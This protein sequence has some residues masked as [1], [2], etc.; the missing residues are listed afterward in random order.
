M[1][2]RSASW[3]FAAQ[4]LG[5]AVA[6]PVGIVLARAL[7]ASG[8]GTLS[9]VQLITQFSVVVLGLG[10][11]SAFLYLA[12]RREVRGRDAAVLAMGLG[13]AAVSVL[14]AAYAI[15]GHG[16]IE[17]LLKIPSG[18]LLLV[19]ILLVGPALVLNLMY[20]VVLGS[21]AVRAATS[22]INVSMALQLAAYAGLFAFGALTLKAAVAVWAASVLGEAVVVSALGLRVRAQEGSPMGARL[23]FERA[24]RYGLTM[25]VATLVGQA[26]LRVDMLL[27]SAHRGTAEVGVYSV[28]VTFAELLWLVPS[29]LNAVMLPKVS[30]EGPVALDVTLRLQRVLWPLTLVAGTV[31]TLIAWPVVPLLY[32]REFS[33]SIIPLALLM[34]GAVAM[35][36]TVLP[37]AY[38]SGSG[39]PGE[40]T[41]ASVA[42]LGV[43]VVA[44]V[45]LI[46]LLGAPGAAIASAVSYSV[47]AAVV[48]RAFARFAEVSY[49]DV[50]L[51]A[52]SDVRAL[53]DGVRQVL[54]GDAGSVQE[55]AP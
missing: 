48:I 42:N 45:V 22:V 14:L 39:R 13:A 28:A 18:P 37:S 6:F 4:V 17:A 51:P 10:L 23:L 54:H 21:G 25:W 44:N 38:L 34:P 9:L 36:A 8:K 46:P 2:V 19:G 32:G 15:V 29:A 26:A 55:V 5:K 40:W 20:Q 11:S 53:V 27:L 7:G 49:R 31:V 33:R 24:Y 3:V 41:K 50:L 47:A 1:R 12:G 30:G 43:N 35:A 52:R 16:R